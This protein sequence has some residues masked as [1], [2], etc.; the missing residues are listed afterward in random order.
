MTE[1]VVPFELH[2]PQS[3]LD[4]L[5]D[6]LRRTRWP[7]AET[8]EGWQQGAPLAAVQ[9]LCSYWLNRYDW[10]RCEATLNDWGQFRTNIDGLGIHFLHIRSPEPDALPLIITHGWPGS[11]L[12]FRRI[13]GPLA[14]P[15]AHGGNRSDAFH[16]VAPCLPG[17][18][19][20]DRPG[21]VGWSVERIAQAWI[22]LMQRLG[23][24]RFVAQGG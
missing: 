7:E 15:A 19:F 2:V 1:T 20:S 14:D 8:V 18:G 22:E 4:D 6:R 3:V 21:K 17:Y 24:T 16:V 5:H 11:I 13:F 9:D 23:Y 10:R 12:E